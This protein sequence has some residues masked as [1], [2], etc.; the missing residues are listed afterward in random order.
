MDPT[1][2]EVPPEPQATTNIAPVGAAL[3]ASL[4][5]LAVLLGWW[6][7]L[8][9]AR[10]LAWDFAP[11]AAR[12]QATLF[13]LLATI[14]PLA[15]LAWS[16]RATWRPL[17][18][19]RLMVEERIVPWFRQ[20]RWWELAALSIAAGVGEELLFRGLLQDAWTAQ[21]GPI[22]GLVFASVAF[23]FGHA[24]SRTYFVL[25]TLMGAYLGLVYWIAGD[26]LAPII[27]HAA[28]DFVALIWLTQGAA[29]NDSR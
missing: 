8:E 6:W 7:D 27:V 13:G 15:A 10:C 19:L 25:A 29:A 16:Q 3:E 28:Y 1:E 24:L 20:S 21:V 12:L 11:A 22:A 9:P 14:P 2:D 18:G 4:G 17:V 23:G 26:L 5:V